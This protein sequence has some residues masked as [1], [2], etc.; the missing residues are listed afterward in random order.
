MTGKYHV[1]R[2][3]RDDGILHVFGE[4]FRLP[5]ETHYEYVIVRIPVKTATH[6]G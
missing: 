3:I 2:F 5:P 4:E 6:S 1:V